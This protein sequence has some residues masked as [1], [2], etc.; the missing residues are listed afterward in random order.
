V[1]SCA[2][3]C[4]LLRGLPY[5]ERMRAVLLLAALPLLVLAIEK[6][7]CSVPCMTKEQVVKNNLT[8]T[9]LPFM[10]ENDNELRCIEHEAILV[11]FVF[12]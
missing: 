4:L 11:L 7:K 8:H 6:E 10:F 3:N 2:A 9:C 1:Q 5:K 12:A